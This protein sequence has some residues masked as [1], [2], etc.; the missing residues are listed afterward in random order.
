VVAELQ[1]TE[2]LQPSRRRRRV[3]RRRRC[4]PNSPTV[5]EYFGPPPCDDC[6]DGADRGEPITT[7]IVSLKE[8]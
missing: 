4:S 7:S 2:D 8:L 3:L 5:R 1:S 6:A